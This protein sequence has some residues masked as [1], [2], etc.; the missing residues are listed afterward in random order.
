[1]WE[2]ILVG[3]EGGEA[4]RRGPHWC[5]PEMVVVVDQVEAKDGEEVGG[6]N[7]L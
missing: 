5:T 4:G 2:K 6:L 7:I 3:S 1:M